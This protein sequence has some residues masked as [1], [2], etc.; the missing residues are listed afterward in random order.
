MVNKKEGDMYL[1]NQL[2][3]SAKATAIE[4]YC[5]HMGVFGL[6]NKVNQFLLSRNGQKLKF[7]E[8]GILFLHE[9]KEFK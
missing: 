4:T 3:E 8:D 2:N 6:E 7:Y 5:K 9:V 1:F